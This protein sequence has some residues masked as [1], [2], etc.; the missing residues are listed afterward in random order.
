MQAELFTC[1]DCSHSLFKNGTASLLPLGHFRYFHLFCGT[2]GGRQ[3]AQLQLT[4]GH[5]VPCER[6]ISVLGLQTKHIPS[7]TP[8]NRHSAFTSMFRRVLILAYKC[9]EFLSSQMPE[10]KHFTVPQEKKY[11]GCLGFGFQYGYSPLRARSRQAALERDLSS[12]ER[13]IFS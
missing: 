3:G 13:Q 11:F 12:R 6:I 10:E 9:T 1:W 2:F 8:L 4:T 7:L 5:V